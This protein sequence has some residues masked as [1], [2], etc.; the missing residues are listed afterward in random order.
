MSFSV[1]YS[2]DIDSIIITI[3]EDMTRKLAIEIG[4][5]IF[6]TIKQHETNKLLFDLRNSRNTESAVT[7]YDFAYKEEDDKKIGRAHV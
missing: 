3:N 2:E 4:D 6:E 1:K 5:K 7:N